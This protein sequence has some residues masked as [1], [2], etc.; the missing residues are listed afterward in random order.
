MQNDYLIINSTNF[1]IQTNSTC[2]L[3]TQAIKRYQSRLFIQDCGRL[4]SALKGKPSFYVPRYENIS[5]VE[6]FSRNYLKSLTV[7]FDGDCEKWPQMDMIEKYKLIVEENGSEIVGSSVWGA[8]RGLETF[9]Q[10][11]G[12]LINFKQII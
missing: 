5:K 9:A 2:D 12:R 4:N 1:Q 10:L 7:S 11:L 3:L 6:K 8:L